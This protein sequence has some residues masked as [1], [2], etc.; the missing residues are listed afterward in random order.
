LAIIWY[1][2][3]FKS[4]NSVARCRRIVP[5]LIALTF[6]A[7]SLGALGAASCYVGWRTNSALRFLEPR[8]A[9]TV[10]E[11]CVAYPI[12]Y[13]LRSD[14]KND[15][16]F[17]GD[18]TCRCG[19]DPVYFEQLTGLRAYN[20]GS[21]GRVGPMGF[22]VTAKAYLLRHPPP[23]L[24]VVS[25]SPVAFE[26]EVA[27]TELAMQSRFLANY[28]PEVPGLLPVTES[29]LYFIQRGSLAARSAGSSLVAHRDGDLDVRDLALIGQQEDTYHTLERRTRES[30]GYGRL[31]GLHGKFL[32]PMSHGRPVEVRSDWDQGLRLLA[33]TCQS[34]QIPLL[35]RLSPMPNDWLPERDFSPIEKWLVEM[36]NSFPQLIVG[37]P[38]LLWYDPKVCWD[39]LHLNREGTEKYTKALAAEVSAA[40][41]ATRRSTGN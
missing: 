25:M 38:P 30:R 13:S 24:I 41:E 34:A 1:F 5:T 40:L 10:D 29:L 11:A 8:R 35:I 22:L 33:E 16:I 18:S 15:V 37:R 19:I 17:L 7:G 6:V 14:E 12:E 39:C 20:L 32:A 31:P 4:M 28:G 9:P 3:A 21:Q 23:R 26:T 36:R 27:G 2:V